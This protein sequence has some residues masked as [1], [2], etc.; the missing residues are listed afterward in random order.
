VAKRAFL[1][2]GLLAALAC[3]TSRP[4]LPYCPAAEE[5]PPVAPACAAEP[6]VQRVKRDLQAIALP[7]AYR[8]LV[9]VTFD[10]AGAVDTVCVQRAKDTDGWNVRSKL[11]AR[12]PEL[13]AVA[14]GPACLADATLDLNRLGARRSEVD[15][16][17]EDCWR[18]ASVGA[19]LASP[20]SLARR[21]RACI[22]REQIQR[23]E[24]WMLE[25][26]QIYVRTPEGKERRES[27]LGCTQNAT[28]IGSS[29]YDA[30]IREVWSEPIDEITQCLRGYGWEALD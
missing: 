11:G 24:I 8:N 10:D 30:E 16:I 21:Y 20:E 14:P 17:S 23:G 7:D 12:G 2:V 26:G 25:R 4:T 3:A 18:E 13:R 5:L 9:R 15:V 27:L 22:E 29:P 6:E 1:L 28:P 19:R